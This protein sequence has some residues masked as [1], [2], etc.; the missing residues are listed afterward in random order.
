MSG[1][2]LDLKRVYILALDGLEHNLVEE[3]DL[4]A[5][6]QA[7][8]G[9]V[10]IS[11]FKDLATPIIWASFITGL[12]PEKH[13][14]EM[15]EWRHPFLQKLHEL[16]PKLKLDKIKG[17]GMIF[18]WLGFKRG[19][20]YRQ[21]IAHFKKYRSKSLF[22]IIPKAKAI[23]VPPYQEWISEKTRKYVSDV[24]H[25]R[26]ALKSYERHIWKI[27]Y[28]KRRRY[29]KT[30]LEGDWNILMTHFMFIDLFG[31]FFITDYDKM[32]E[33]YLEAEQ[34]VKDTQQ[35]IDEETWLLIISDHG[36]K[37][38]V[39]EARVGDHS[40]H[41]FYSSNVKLSLVNPKITDFFDLVTGTFKSLID[42]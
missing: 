8:Y 22:H 33:V 18:E 40:D 2:R 5:L 23:S 36:M 17:K 37:P 32:L 30:L 38:F 35:L 15:T 1:D 20:D 24:V 14:I 12:P 13:K 34:L 41:G 9:K 3:F 21:N 26:I 31:H 27:F 25:R 16:M 28:E 39:D 11:M 4:E 29:F 42:R 10:D 7:E 19:E 6:K